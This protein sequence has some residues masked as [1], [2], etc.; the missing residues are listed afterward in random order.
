MKLIGKEKTESKKVTSYN[1]KK[2]LAELGY[3]MLSTI[4]PVAVF[5]FTLI[6]KVPLVALGLIL[7]SKWQTF[8]V[9][10]RFLWAN[11]K[12]NALDLIFKLSIWVELVLISQKLEDFSGSSK[13]ALWVL[14]AFVTTGYIFWNTY[15]KKK[16]S[17]RGM[18]AQG[19]VTIFSAT[20]A[21][22]W[23][24]A[25]FGSTTLLNPAAL[26]LVWAA[27]YV[28]A[29]HILYAQEESAVGQLSA[30]WATAATFIFLINSYWSYGFTLM[31]GA[32]YLPIAAILITFYA[33]LAARMHS[34]L[35]D[36]QSD[37]LSKAELGRRR[38]DLAK[39]AVGSLV[40]S[41]S[42][43]LFILLK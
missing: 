6:I 5:V 12:L 1:F 8:V 4:L 40:L 31:K 10:P 38:E 23:L 27:S 21:L 16:S 20:T 2:A 35:E 37:E 32:V 43:A 29:Q 39:L 42:M 26:A 13:I 19:L 9:K 24:E 17:P 28:V 25:G 36:R 15:L 18:L 14:A 3:T 30:Y 11:I 33:Y 22:V 41:L 7:L 34:F